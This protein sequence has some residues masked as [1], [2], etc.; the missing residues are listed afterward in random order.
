MTCNTGRL[1]RTIRVIVGVALVTWGIAAHSWWGAIGLIPLVTAAIG[2]C[3]L[4][5]PL[6]IST[7]RRTQD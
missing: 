7:C 3:P 2:W 4:Y 5:A 6:R 1:D